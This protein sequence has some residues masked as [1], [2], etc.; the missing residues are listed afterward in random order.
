MIA[1]DCRTIEKLE[2]RYV[3]TRDVGYDNLIIDTA[4]P[5]PSRDYQGPVEQSLASQKDT[6]K[7]VPVPPF[8][9]QKPQERIENGSNR[10]PRDVKVCEIR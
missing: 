8:D 9:Q 7:Y 10:I 2:V 6:A 1:S 3:A 4:G 5:L